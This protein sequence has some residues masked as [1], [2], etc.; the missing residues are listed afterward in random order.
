MLF[1]IDEDVGGRLEGWV[2]PD[3]PAVTPRVI[4]HL[5]AAHH[6][7]IEAFV[8]RP[9]LKE[10]GLH[11]T[12]ICGFVLDEN[13]CPG[14]TDA[15][16]LEIYD[17]DNNLLLYRRRSSGG[18]IDKKFFRL[19]PQ[20]FRSVALDE[21]LSPRFH[22]TYT[23]LDSLPE[24]TTRSVLAIAFSPSI[25]AEGRVFWRV[26]E[27]LLR[28]RG[29]RV[30]MLLRDPYHELAE[31]LLILKLA[32]SPAGESIMDALGPMVEGA[33]SRMRHVDLN[34]PSDIEAVLATPPH[35]LRSVLYN[36]LTYLLTAQNVFDPPPTPATAVALDSLADMDAIGLRRDTRPFLETVSAILELPEYP[37]A[38]ALPTSQ[39]VLQLAD[40]LRDKPTA[41]GLI[42]MDLE[43]F[44]TVA[45]TLA[46]VCGD[47]IAN[48]T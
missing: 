44:E 47:Q 19:E 46:N 34:D 32:N 14:L 17:A 41:R 35:E 31:R 43:V 48:S 24:E 18:L 22:M 29:F 25:Y 30:G 15:G 1:S 42:E 28:D 33:A 2:M 23:A 45:G 20:L 40:V 26:W 13:N 38:I 7:V 3:N 39:T 36:P 9:L 11:N 10:Y 5:S 27:P 6:V 16:E 21:L 12:G 37:Q 4:T 8:F